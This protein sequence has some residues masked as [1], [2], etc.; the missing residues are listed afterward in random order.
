M[1]IDDVFEVRIVSSFRCGVRLSKISVFTAS[2]S[3]TA[4]M[5]RSAPA[6]VSNFV[7]D[8][9]LSKASS[10]SFNEILPSLTWR[11]K[12]VTIF[13]TFVFNTSFEMSESITLYPTIAIDWAIPRPICPDPTIPIVLIII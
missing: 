9:K 3:V 4:S 5:I 7:A 10:H 12:L 8:F 13:S 11:V 2:S 1:E 6:T